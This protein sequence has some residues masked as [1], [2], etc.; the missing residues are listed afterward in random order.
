MVVTRGMVIDPTTG[1]SYLLHFTFV[2]AQKVL[3][4]ILIR[5]MACFFKVC[6]LHFLKSLFS[7]P[8]NVIFAAFC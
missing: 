2:L 6:N 1:K 3:V 7:L 4:I 8:G 5:I